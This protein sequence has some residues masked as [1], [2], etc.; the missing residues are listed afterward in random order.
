MCPW[1]STVWWTLPC[2]GNASCFGY[3]FVNGVKKS[4]LSI[5]IVQTPIYV[6]HH[7]LNTRQTGPTSHLSPWGRCKWMDEAEAQTKPGVS[8]YSS[9]GTQPGSRQCQRSSLW[10]VNESTSWIWVQYIP[11]QPHTLPHFF[12][13][14]HRIIRH[15][16]PKL[17][18]RMGVCK[19]IRSP[20]GREVGWSQSLSPKYLSRNLGGIPGQSKGAIQTCCLLGS[21]SLLIQH[22]HSPYYFFSSPL[23]HRDK[24]QPLC[25]KK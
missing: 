22:F 3:S 7:R 19:E 13:L 25:S 10:V 20:W 17:P 15:S 11:S 21:G 24:K 2:V 1:V 12:L 4:L 9:E 6:G 8:I 18:V 5:A 23:C 14:F 16:K